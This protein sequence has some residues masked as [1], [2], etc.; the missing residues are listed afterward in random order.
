VFAQVKLV[1]LRAL[2]IRRIDFTTPDKRRA[3]L[4]AEALALYEAGDREAL[5]SCVDARLNARPEEADVVHD[6]LASLAETM[7]DLHERRA[8]VLERFWLDLE[9]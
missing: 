7:I 6:L 3:D 2:P 9:G 5:L 8:A 1:D 4:L